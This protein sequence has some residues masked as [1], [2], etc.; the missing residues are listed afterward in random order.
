LKL[1][2]PSLSL[3]SLKLLLEH[4]FAGFDGDLYSSNEYRMI[5]WLISDVAQRISNVLTTIR[6]EGSGDQQRKDWLIYLNHIHCAY[7]ELAQGSFLVKFD[8]AF[9]TPLAH[10]TFKK[11]TFLPSFESRLN[12][13]HY[14]ERLIFLRRFKSLA[15][16]HRGLP[17][18]DWESY[19]KLVNEIRKDSVGRND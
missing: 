9:S 12:F 7:R 8:L 1:I 11:I 3:L 4:L 16:P 10:M 5:Y 2:K 14:N 18:P 6:N 17:T 19:V 15:V 13:D